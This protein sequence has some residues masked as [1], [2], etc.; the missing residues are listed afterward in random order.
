MQ[1]NR[2]TQNKTRTVIHPH[3]QKHNVTYINTN[4]LQN[5][6]EQAYMRMDT[7]THK[8]RGTQIYTQTYHN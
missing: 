7:N 2:Q 5:T 1:R 4:T 6:Q 8:H 3:K